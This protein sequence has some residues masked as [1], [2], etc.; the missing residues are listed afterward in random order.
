MAHYQ[1]S[2]SYEQNSIPDGKEPSINPQKLLYSVSDLQQVLGIGRSLAY[3]LLARDDF[4]KI[5][6]N[7]RY[8]IPVDALR[9]WIEK[10]SRRR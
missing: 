5:V 4:P 6:I 10:E 7:G 1:D 9:R 3:M 2:T 8:F